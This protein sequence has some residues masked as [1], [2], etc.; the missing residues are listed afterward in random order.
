[1]RILIVEDDTSLQDLMQLYLA[2]YGT[3]DVASNGIEALEAVERAIVSG[4]P[5]DLVCMD[6]MMPEMN[7][8][9]ALQK[10]R[11]LEFKHY[12]ERLASV[13]M[14]MITAKDMAKDMMSAYNAGCEAYITKPFTQEKLF[15]Q[16]RKLGLMETP[17]SNGESTSD[18]SV[19]LL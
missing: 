19:K 17:D 2:D 7:G 14:I 11:R 16:I 10:I 18:D 6:V 13:K 8:L 9:E 3:C 5:Y 15:E 4:E 1:M 12:A